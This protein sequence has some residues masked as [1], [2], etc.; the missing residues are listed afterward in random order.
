MRRR[1]CLVVAVS[2]LG[3]LPLSA[4]A[5]DLDTDPLWRA[6]ML[7]VQTAED[8]ASTEGPGLPTDPAL[9]G[10]V[11]LSGIESTCTASC[12]GTSTV[13]CSTSGTCT[14][15][16]RSCPTQ[17]GY[18]QCGTTKTNCPF[19]CPV[20]NCGQNGICATN[21]SPP[22]PDCPSNPCQD[23]PAQGCYYVWSP[24]DLCCYTSNA[25]CFDICH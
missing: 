6:L 9:D 12:G 3:L 13:S 21:C 25:G 2:F 8:P 1:L 19:A 10:K 23:N 11:L 20:N 7:E 14:A 15:V 18:V 22:D 24:Q 16:D 5:A 4:V 17:R